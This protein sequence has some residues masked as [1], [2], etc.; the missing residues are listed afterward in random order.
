MKLD[1]SKL[2]TAQELLELLFTEK[3]RPKVRWLHKMKEKR[4]VPYYKLNGKL[5]FDPVK[6][7][8]YWE[9]KGIIRAA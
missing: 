3:S 5:L 6:V 4:R 8:E 1:M 2:V 7:R 9:K